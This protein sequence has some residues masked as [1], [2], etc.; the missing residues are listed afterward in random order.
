KHI[1]IECADLLEIRK[2]YFEEKSLYSLFRKVIPEV[3]FDFL[4]A[5]PRA[6][7]HVVGMLRFMSLT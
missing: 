6:H 5:S 2:K 1:L 3:I 7:L 4:R